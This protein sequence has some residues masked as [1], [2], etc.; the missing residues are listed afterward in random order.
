MGDRRLLKA[1]QRRQLRHWTLFFGTCLAIFCFLFV[2][3]SP[4]D[5]SSSK[6]SSSPSIARPPPEILENLSLTEDQCDAAFP[7]LTKE[8]D[9]VVSKGPFTVKQS[10]DLGPLQ[11]RIKDGQIYIL[12]AQ[13]KSDLSQEMVNSRT[14]AL[15][16]LHRAITTSPT[17]LP[18]TIFTLNIQD[19]PFG[20]AW[21]Y[22]R[23]ASPAHKS[24][25]PNAR[26]FLMPH[27]SFWAWKLP[28]VG[29]V[30]RASRA[31][32]A[33]ESAFSGPGKWNQ[34]I[35][36]AV[37]RGTT[38][39][40]SIQAPRLRQQL[41]AAAKNKPWADVQPLEWSGSGS[42][43]TNALAIEDFCR[44]K[45][46]V[47]TEGVSYSGRFQFLQMCASVV[48]TPPLHWLQHTTHLVKPLFSS[49][50]DLQ[51]RKRGGGA[52][53]WD[54]RKKKSS[55]SKKKKS[56]QKVMATASWEPS[57]RTK[58]TWPV[59]YGPE[60]ANIVFVAPDWSD[61][62]D[63]VAWLEA[64]PRVA[65]GIAR[66]QRDLFFGGG[67]FSPAAEGCYW[68]ALVRGWAQMARTD[69]EDWDQKEGITFEAF[70][71]TNGD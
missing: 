51:D 33:I 59:Q 23:P 49:S 26:S 20:T 16:Q 15:H 29:S 22:S 11:G 4:S 39:F 25:D 63:V 19:Q 2:F 70:S 41:V 68:R 48:L 6:R 37:W 52:G 31:I 64:N 10:G 13:R 46:V 14:A 24:S 27:F 1:R 66:R 28:F 47:H 71:L 5:G 58:D 42:N 61:L 56:A 36:K 9:D 43:A 45:Y 50:L 55:S 7:G 60:E 57:S 67:Y 62:E 38:W 8:I 3:R 21:T 44:Y 18:D 53:R 65:E 30:A 35:P 40:N 54:A 69:G 12:H 34:K 32:T 17:R